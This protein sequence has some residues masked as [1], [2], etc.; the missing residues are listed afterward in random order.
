MRPLHT[1]VLCGRCWFVGLMMVAL[2][3]CRPADEVRSYSVPAESPAAAS[4][5]AASEPAERGA[6]THRMLAAIVPGGGQAWFV[7]AV[8]PIDS[9]TK[10]AVELK[11]LFE[12]L[13]IEAD[14]PTWKT[15][16]GWGERPAEGMRLATLDSPEAM[17]GIEVTV[18]GLPLVGEWAAQVL[19][20]AN[21]WLGQLG[22]EAMTAATLADKT[23]KLSAIEGG[24]VLDADGWFSG[25]MAPGGGAA[26]GGAPFAAG[27]PRPGPA[28][29]APPAGQG[30][31]AEGPLEFDTPKGWTDKPGSAM[32][33][34]SLATPGGAEVTAFAFPATAP[35][36]ADPLENVNRW[37]G[38]VG[39]G[40]TTASA[41]AAESE[42]IEISGRPADYVVLEGATETTLAAMSVR[43]DAVWFYKVR[44]PKAEVATQRDAFRAWLASIR[45]VD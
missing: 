24:V 38:E 37:R 21:R 35:A 34:A 5:Q 45:V 36:M 13:R 20:N 14:R 9:V 42:K 30:G 12:S 44:G 10:A 39:L 18:I 8:G 2:G 19:D 40:P 6:P 28:T 3:G 22:R 41:L 7:K 32:R 43:G 33:L 26:L 16:E 27:G 1:D 4:T 25:G 15:P 31:A 23:T 11:S 17:P 29:P